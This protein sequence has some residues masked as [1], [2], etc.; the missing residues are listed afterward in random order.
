MMRMGLIT[1]IRRYDGRYIVEFSYIEF[2][3]LLNRLHCSFL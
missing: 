1:L 3:I 2:Y